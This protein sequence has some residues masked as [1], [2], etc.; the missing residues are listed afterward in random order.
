MRERERERSLRNFIKAIDEKLFFNLLRGIWVS[1]LNLE[2]KFIKKILPDSFFVS[3]KRQGELKYWRQRNYL[4][5]A[6]QF[7]KEKVLEKYSIENATWIE[8]GTYRGDTTHYLSK[9]F[10]HI[11]SIEPKVEFYKA[12][13][14]RFKSQNVTLFNDVSENVL[15]ILLPTLRGNL[16]FWLDG[17]YSGGETFKG[18]KE[19]PI[20]DELNSIEVNF[21]NFKKISIFIDDVRLFLYSANDYPSIDY[22][23]DWSRRLNMKWRIEHDIFIIHKNN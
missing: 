17:H 10:P 23:V 7:I 16:N 15:P 2:V 4:E 6:P 12:A 18:N 9:K 19:C 21:H 11:Y 5:N 3:I 14:N 13:L 22:L 8:T 20:K 1:F